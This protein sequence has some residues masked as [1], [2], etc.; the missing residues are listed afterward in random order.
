MRFRVVV[1]RL[2][3][4]LPLDSLVVDITGNFTATLQRT[5]EVRL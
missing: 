2:A 1:T 3:L 5:Q 4:S